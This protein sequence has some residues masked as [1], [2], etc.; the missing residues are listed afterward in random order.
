MK[1]RIKS[2]KW[3]MLLLMLMFFMLLGALLGYTWCKRHMTVK[4]SALQYGIAEQRLSVQSVLWKDYPAYRGLT[5]TIS[6]T[7]SF[8]TKPDGAVLFNDLADSAAFAET[9]REHKAL[10]NEGGLLCYDYVTYNFRDG[11]VTVSIPKKYSDNPIAFTINNSYY[12]TFYEDGSD[13]IAGW[14]SMPDTEYMSWTEEESRNS[15][16]NLEAYLSAFA[17]SNTYDSVN[18]LRQRTPKAGISLK[19]EGENY[20]SCHMYNGSMDDWNYENQL[21]HI[22]LWYK[23]V[24]MEFIPPFDY[25]LT[26]AV[27]KP[28]ETRQFEVPKEIIEQY[29][30]LFPGIYRLVI[31]G[32]HEEF[33]VSDAF[34]Y[35]GME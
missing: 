22:E 11:E 8:Y 23:G 28:L 15:A 13:Y 29:S 33:I 25:N 21:P 5:F 1:E 26:N 6:G 27:I 35:D 24:W 16:V 4:K 34:F 19:Q 14:I 17:L 3:I 20:L 12:L 18:P 30:T 31:Y 7:I 32:E 9:G 2:K 10:R